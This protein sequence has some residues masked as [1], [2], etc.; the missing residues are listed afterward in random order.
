MG[1]KRSE[2]MLVGLGMMAGGLALLIGVGLPQWDTYSATNTQ[3]A[4]LNDEI[5]L[6]DSQKTSLNAQIALLEKNTDIPSDIH[7]RTY[8]EQNQDEVIKA[9]LDQ[10]VNMATDTGNKFISLNPDD[11]A[12]PIMPPPPSADK[13][14]AKA[15][16]QAANTPVA[17]D[18]ASG[19]PA[20]P[21]APPA[22][23]PPLLSTFGYDLSIRGTYDSLQGFLRSLDS[24]KELMEVSAI[25]IENEAGADRAGGDSGATTTSDPMHPLKLTASVRIVLQPE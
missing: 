25:Q 15:G 17:G 11:K 16:S 8:T 3:I 7:I 10:L 4:S 5:K 21:N 20:D 18:A 22:V 12:E 9:M 1:L 2:K 6:L 14:K 19:Q 24:Q 23:P 13:D